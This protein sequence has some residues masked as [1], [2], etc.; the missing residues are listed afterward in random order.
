[1]SRY[2]VAVSGGVDSVVLLD[3]L[4][5][6]PEHE[7]VVAHFDHGIRS[8]SAEDA[9]FVEAL[10]RNYGLP[11]ETRREE[12]GVEA[13]EELARERRYVFLREMA[14]KHSARIV[15]AHHADDAIE[16]LAINLK[17]GTGW[18]GLAALDSPDISRPLLRAHKSELHDYALKQR[19]EWREDST[20]ASDVYLRNRLR[21]LVSA[22]PHIEKRQLLILRE[23]QLLCRQL[24]D[25]EVTRLVGP[26]PHYSRYFFTHVPKVVAM[27]CLRFVTDARL[28]RPQLERALLAIKTA[29][30]GHAYEAGAGITLR[31]TTRNFS[32]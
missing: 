19:L 20:N 21:R 7:Y 15:T 3:K 18:R 30:K 26:G 27:E 4:T 12:L 14:D 17:R 10:A 16:T 1:M 31:F 13:S 6:V 25:K 32:L 24:I 22:V 23:Q 11:F 29:H 9:L 2:I 8:D 28:T 5:K